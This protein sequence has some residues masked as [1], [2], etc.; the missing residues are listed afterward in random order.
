M[1]LFIGLGRTELHLSVPILQLFKESGQQTSL[2]LS[3]QISL[4]VMMDCCDQQ[5]TSKFL[6]RLPAAV[7]HFQSHTTLPASNLPDV[8]T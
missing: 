5:T 2:Q 1:P 4:E 7:L 8:S 6:L 3:R